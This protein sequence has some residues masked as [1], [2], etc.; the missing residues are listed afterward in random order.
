MVENEN[1]DISPAAVHWAKTERPWG[2]RVKPDGKS[3]SLN[4]ADCGKPIPKDK[5][6]GVG[7]CAVFWQ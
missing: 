6:T 4:S 1:P 2:R 3:L 5:G 7:V